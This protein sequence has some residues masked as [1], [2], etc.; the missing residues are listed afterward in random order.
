MT[1]GGRP[2]STGGVALLVPL[3]ARGHMSPSELRDLISR[4]SATDSYAE[5]WPVAWEGA[6][7][8]QQQHWLG[9]LD[10]YDG[11]GYYHRSDWHRDARFVYNH[12]QCPPMIVWLGEACGLPH[13]TL[14]PAFQAACDAGSSPASQCAA[15]RRV[16]RWDDLA[17]RLAALGADSPHSAT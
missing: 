8:T 6:G 9:W 4:L 11:P 10:G 1:V 7:R 13:A 15:A 3:S 5:R 14:E 16:I 12:I 2:T 17:A